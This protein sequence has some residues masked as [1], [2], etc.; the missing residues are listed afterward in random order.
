M[1]GDQRAVG[2]RRASGGRVAVLDGLRLL[3]ATMV[4]GYHYIA[5]PSAKLGSQQTVR[6]E[7]WGVKSETLF[8]HWLHNVA[9]FGWTGVELFFLISG[10]VICMSGW[11]RRPAD[12]FVS[13]VVRLV[14]AYWAATLI[15]TIVLVAW[16][17]LSGGVQPSIVLANMTMVQS[18]Y[19]VVNFVPAYWTLLVELTF[20][21]LFGIVAIGGITYRRMVTFCV[22]WSI[23]SIIAVTAHDPLFKLIINPLYSAYFVAGI[24]FFL[25]YKFGGN[26]LLWGIV[27]YSWL[28]S[29][30]E[31]RLDAPWQLTLVITAMFVVMA[32]VATHKLDRVQWRWLTVAGALTYPL[33]LVHQDIG[34][35]IFSYLSQKMPATLLVVLVYLAM[36]GLAWVIHRTIERPVA[37]LLK[38]KLSEAVAKVRASGPRSTPVLARLAGAGMAGP[39]ANG[40]AGNGMAGNG[41]AANGMAERANGAG[42]AGAGS[43]G[44]TGDGSAAGGSAAG[45]ASGG[46]AGVGAGYRRAGNGNGR[47][48]SYADLRAV[49]AEQPA[50]ESEDGAL[51]GL[52][53]PYE[54]SYVE[55]D[56]DEAT[57]EPGKRAM[58]G[59]RAGRLSP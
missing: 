59:G 39:A 7:A 10:F 41:A 57:A 44:G 4:V 35:T 33:Y 58:T 42:G 46:S 50:Q 13:R 20:Y 2:A 15:T 36:L 38:A 53:D 27:V 30:N 29:V 3:A 54:T 26:L 40:A 17:K 48:R 16:P 19:G 24:A 34:F 14:P 8:P 9:G 28:I 25:I 5:A 1:T 49:R 55:R 22:L 23:A 32:L 45:A 12:F 51:G 11:G 6:A 37:P 43:G 56:R 47:A 21:L 18:A 52:G 31:P